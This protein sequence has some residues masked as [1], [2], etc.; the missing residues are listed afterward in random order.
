[1]TAPASSQPAASTSTIDR[2]PTPTYPDHLISELT[3]NGF[4]RD[5]AAQELARTSGDVQK[6]LLNLLA[7]A[8]SVP[9][10]NT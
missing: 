10:K 3:A 8:I 1:M 5:E 4:T 9:P 6:A 2:G 7:K